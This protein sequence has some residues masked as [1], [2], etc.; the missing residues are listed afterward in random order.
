VDVFDGLGV[1]DLSR[2]VPGEYAA[3]LFA[4]FGAEVV[5]VEKPGTGSL[6]RYWTPRGDLCPDPEAS[7]LFLHLNTNKQSIALDLAASG[8]DRA[9]LL[10]LVR[11]CDAIIESFP[12][13][14]LERFRLGPDTLR[15]VN[16]SVVLTRISPFG[17]PMNAT[18]A[19]GRGPLRKPGNLEHYTVGRA[20]AEATLAGLIAVRRGAPGAII[21]VSAHEVLLSGADRRA[22]YLLAASYSGANAPRGVR[23]A[24]RGLSKFTGPFRTGDGYVMVYVTNQ[25]FLDRLIAMVAATDPAFGARFSGQEIRLENFADFTQEMR[26][27]FAARQK[28]EIMEL[29]ERARIP[30]TAYLTM[31]EILENPHYRERRTF[32]VAGHPQ[33]GQ[34][35]YPAAPWR[36]AG[37]YQLRRTAPL[38]DQDGA[39][40]RARAGHLRRAGLLPLDWP[41]RAPG[42]PPAG[43][44]HLPLRGIRVVDLTVVWSG[45]GGT[46]L[47][48]DLGA[49]VI[50]LEGNNRMRRNDS[51]TWTRQT[52]AN[53]GYRLAAYP[54][55]EPQ[56]RPYDRS[57][58]FN[59]HA[60]NKLAACANLETP[61]GR[62]ALLGLL[63]ISDVLVENNAPATLAKLGLDTDELR[64]RYPRLIIARMPP[65]GLTGPMADYLGYGP[66]FN[67]LTGIGMLEGYENEDPGSSGDNYH[68]DEASPWGIA[69]AVLAALWHRDRTGAGDLIEFA[70]SENVLQEVGEYLLDAQQHQ[71]PPPAFGNADP[72]LLQDVF[73]AAGEDSWVA[74][75]VRDDRDWSA[76]C[77]AAG[78]PALAAH[79]QTRPLRRQHSRW[80]RGR[81]AAWVRPQDAWQ[82]VSAL[83]AA[84]VPVS[85]VM[86]E[87]RVLADPHL[88]A[89]EWFQVRHHPA[90]GT[91]RYPGLPWRAAGFDTVYGRPLPGFGEDNQYVY[92]AL[93]GYPDERYAQLRAHG[94][95]T[96]EQFA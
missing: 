43:L 4:D 13:G 92:Q 67:A 35:R 38:L 29:A 58:M 15:A 94:L 77:R 79:G 83:R 60:R 32:A 3:K 52:L 73:P 34:L 20:A 72:V 39:A 51:A 64:A 25:V 82:V 50:R 86:P 76:L 48:G 87:T 5:K 10:D 36:M 66:N 12:P 14:R 71:T 31:R 59:W 56:P 85:E 45:P 63:A 27:W 28:L 47:L 2:W 75:S 1:L 74:I 68:M 81:I 69:F 46:A 7:P 95:V 33:A 16:P 93:L 96:D 21:D 65:M 91:H 26:D 90:V 9:V 23:S 17:G 78:D 55:C 22:A 37:G 44:G 80:L 70:Q 24:H 62:D 84:G 11:D 54:D 57:A 30:I 8:P 40:L 42:Q 49:E 89:R 19:A 6:T 88:A 53:A 18:G 61:A 41:D